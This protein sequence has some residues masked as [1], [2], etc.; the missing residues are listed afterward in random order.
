M[1][2][3]LTKSQL[4]QIIQEE[5]EALISE[6]ESAAQT[7]AVA[8][9]KS[10]VG[11]PLE[12]SAEGE[13]NAS[14]FKRPSK[15]KTGLNL[16]KAVGQVQTGILGTGGSFGGLPGGLGLKGV[17]YKTDIGKNTSLTLGA[18]TSGLPGAGTT[19][20]AGIKLNWGEGLS[21]TKSQL[22][23]IILEALLNEEAKCE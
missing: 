8:K 20:G 7:L 2:F 12:A 4:K 17:K 13:M 16:G 5:Y 19:Y 21:L 23:Q 15:A 9:A 1:K 14:S 18:G 11:E 6:E 22:K 3:A 10:P